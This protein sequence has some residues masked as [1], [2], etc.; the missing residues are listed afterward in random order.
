M[1]SA[2]RRIPR[3]TDLKEIETAARAHLGEIGRDLEAIRFRLLGVEA[4][5]PPGPVEM[6]HLL[7]DDEM[8]VRT[9][10]RAE[11]Q[12]V[13]NAMIEPAIRDLRAMA[14]SPQKS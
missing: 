11:I 3:G 14:V 4:T 13:L 10:I 1:N 6:A 7:E 5:V 2:R 12:H 8:D 9:E